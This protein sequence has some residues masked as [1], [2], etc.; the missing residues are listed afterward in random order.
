[1]R[2]QDVTPEYIRAMQAAGFKFDIDDVIAAKV[3]DI[4]PAFI[5]RA[6]K[7]GFKNLTLRKLIQLKP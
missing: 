7:H 6:R 4:T 3:Q 2:V 5:E 1:M